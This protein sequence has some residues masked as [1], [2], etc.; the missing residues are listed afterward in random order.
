MSEAFY[1]EYLKNSNKPMGRR[2]TAQLK[3]SKRDFPGGPLAKT[4]CSQCRGPRLD[5]WPG[6]LYAAAKSLLATTKDWRSLVPQP[7]PGTAK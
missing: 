3:N 5:P 1:P 2:P 6:I 7:K 4:P